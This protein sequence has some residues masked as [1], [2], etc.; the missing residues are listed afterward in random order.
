MKLALGPILYFWKR[1][2]VFEFYRNAA[3]W[4]VDIVYLGEIICSKRRELRR[5]DWLAIAADLA[6]AGKQ[7]VLSTLAL[8]EA[9]SEL[10]YMRRLI[11][12]GRFAIEANDM[13]AVNMAAGR[14]PF[15]AGPHINAYNAG[16]LA[17]LRN[18]GATRWV[19]PLELRR[20]ALVQLQAQR[21]AGMQTEVFAFGRLPLSF[22][23]RCFTARAHN[24]GKDQCGFRCLDTPDGM[25]VLTQEGQSLLVLN[26]IQTLS[27]QSYNLIA[28]IEDMR[29]LGVDVVRLSPQTDGMAEIIAAFHAALAG[30]RGAPALPLTDAPCNGYWYGRP[31]LDWVPYAPMTE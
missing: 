23:A 14:V 13:A 29:R 30:T 11:D 6:D 20:E 10:S 19:M 16:T 4:Q 27:G 8:I 26:G 9:E 25:P 3:A 2:A 21:P 15:V 1:D 31:G 28:E 17:L 12:N 22:S 5:D 7:V 24:V 18:L